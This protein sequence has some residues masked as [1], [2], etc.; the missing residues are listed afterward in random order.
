MP[1]MCYYCEEDI[2]EGLRIYDIIE[3]YMVFFHL[4]PKNCWKKYNEEK[5]EKLKK[6]EKESVKVL[7][8]D[9]LKIEK[10][11]WYKLNR[12]SWKIGFVG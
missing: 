6:L 1:V 4:F 10:V 7:P 8:K 2:L 3:N 9:D 11:K 5:K 12:E